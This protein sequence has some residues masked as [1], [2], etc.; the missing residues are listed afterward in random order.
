MAANRT[1]GRTAPDGRLIRN[2]TIKV[3]LHPEPAQAELIEKTFGCCRY[4]WNHILAD[5]EEFYAAADVHFLPTPA[6]YKKEAPFLKEVDSQALATVHQQLRQAFQNFFRNPQ[7]FHHPVYKTKK[8]NRNSY[9]IYRSTQAA[10][11]Y[12]TPKG[13]R[14][15]KLGEVRATLYRKPLHWWTLKS[16]TVSRSKTG[17][18]F[19]SLVYEYTV[20]QPPAVIPVRERTVGLNLSLTHFYVDSDGR[21]AD[22]P[23]RMKQSVEKLEELQRRL[24]GMEYGSQNYQ[25]QLRKL[26]F[27]H[28][29]IANQRKDFIHKESRRIANEW[30][31]VCVSDTDLR[32]TARNLKL[33]SVMELGFGF[34]R[35]CLE[36]KLEQQGKAYITVER[37]YPSARTCHDCG[38]IHEGLTLRE[39]RW[40]C[41]GCGRIVS[42]EIN[43]SRNLRDAGLAQFYHKK[44]IA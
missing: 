21:R 39:R 31:A 9:T 34:F 36:Y 13:I 8:Q 11:L 28:E 1:R 20:K 22:P 42:R 33:I 24:S 41:P 27:L 25:K 12:L 10:T 43:A 35:L 26:Q 19:A 7:A 29:R 38:H 37:F 4:I 15:P 18:Y 32:K 3:R 30:D 44:T 23:R 14:F 17:K 6:K 40:R 2:T 16:A 5:Q